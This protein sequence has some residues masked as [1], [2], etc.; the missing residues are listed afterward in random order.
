MVFEPAPMQSARHN[1]MPSQMDTARS[2]VPIDPQHA[3]KYNLAAIN[4]QNPNKL[5]HCGSDPNVL[6]RSIRVN[7]ENSIAGLSNVKQNEMD[8]SDN[9]CNSR[10]PAKVAINQ[11][12][13]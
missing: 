5:K 8:G 11:N 13:R 4:R 3:K 12:S 2:N 7:A 1:F 6:N 10:H 9:S